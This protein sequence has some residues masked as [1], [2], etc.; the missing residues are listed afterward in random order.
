MLDK[1]G[2]EGG[3]G[4]RILV[5]DD[6][7]ASRRV[8]KRCLAGHHLAEAADGETALALLDAEEFDLVLLD[9]GL[10]GIDGYEVLRRIRANPTTAHVMVLMVSAQGRVGSVVKG[11]EYQADDYIV[12]PF[13][14][15]ELVA[16][17]NSAL[18]LKRLQDELRRINQDLEAEVRARTQQLLAQQQ[19]ALV[20]RNAAQLAHNLNNPLTAV[21]GLAELALMS[22]ADRRDELLVQIGEVAGEMAEIIGRLLR[23]V[24]SRETILAEAER[25][26]L[27]EVVREQLAFWQVDQRFRYHTEVVTELAED[28]PRVL[29]VRADLNQIFTNLID[30]ALDALDGRPVRRITFRTAAA[31]GEVRCDV[32]D[33]GAG[34]APEHLARIFEPTFTTKPVGQGTGLGL[35]SCYEL[36]AAFQ[37]RLEVASELGVGTTF[38]LVLPCAGEPVPLSDAAAERAGHRAS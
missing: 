34:I 4:A 25:I 21:M 12:K 15:E 23:G 8:V 24:R 28:L 35:A 19:Y 9:I 11:F 38:C 32:E 31:E 27:N 2:S 26:D 18:R 6:S 7:A 20:G 3:E 37:G 33:T 14:G 13:W 5:V 10:P 22:P 29:A 1:S 36:A 17:V 16:R 30:N